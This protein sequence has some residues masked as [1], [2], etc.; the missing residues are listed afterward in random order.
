MVG[1]AIRRPRQVQVRPPS[2]TVA[3]E[4]RGMSDGL[5]AV[6]GTMPRSLVLY[7]SISLGT[8]E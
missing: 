1:S 2:P 4:S 7:S 5:S 6:D 8:H 3:A